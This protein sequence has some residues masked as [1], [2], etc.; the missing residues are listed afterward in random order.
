MDEEKKRVDVDKTES[1]RILYMEDDPGLARLVQRRLQKR[2]YVVDI[3]PDGEQGL[4]MYRAA[5]Y[6]LLLIDQVMPV[7][8]GLEVIRRLASPG[9]LP[10]TIMVTGGGSER[11]AVEAMQLG[12]SDYIVKDASGGFFELLPS[13]IERALRQQRLLEE[14][15]QARQRLLL[16]ATALE[17]AAEGIV[18]TDR[19]GAVLWANSAFEK[20][21]GYA[22][23]EV[24]GRNLR[25]LR[26][27]QHPP[28][29]YEQMWNTILSGQTWHGELIN[30]HKDGTLYNEEMTI[31]PVRGSE[32]RITH[33]VA[34][35]RDVTL[36]KRAEKA[37]RRRNRELVLLNRLAQELT[38]TLDLQQVAER[39]LEDVTDITDAQGASVWLWDEERG[40]WL[41]CRAAFRRGSGRT[42]VNSR[43]R[44]GQGVAGWVAQTGKGAVVR[45][46][47]VDDR[48]FPE[49]DRETGFRT[50]SLLAVPLW[51][52]GKVVGTLEVVNKVA[53][54]FVQDDLDLLETLAIPAA[55][56]IDNARLIQAQR[57]YTAELQARNEELDA[58]AHTV[59]H[60]LKG[61]LG[62]VVGFAEVLEQD[63][64][65]VGDDELQRYLSVIAQHGRKMKNIVDE[66]L[67]L[68]GV[69]KTNVQL[70]RLDMARIVAEALARLSDM[71]EKLGAEVVLPE[72]DWPE[73]WGYAPWVEEVW[74][75]YLSNAIKYGGRPPRVELGFDRLE[76]AGRGGSVRFWVHDNGPGLSS[77][78]RAQLFVPFARISQVRVEGHGLGLSI[79]R[80]I[81]EKLGGQVGV[82]SDGR[83]GHG[84]RFFFTL[85]R[86]GGAKQ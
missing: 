35:K 67:L 77:E 5:S 70:D 42:P 23:Q 65:G 79:V 6:D 15:E 66:L 71:I 82:E 53:G 29:F 44:I 3:A 19:E 43:L 33:F 4:A 59:A 45:D 72:T 34:I 13:V 50:R 68:A 32:A 47:A 73:A 16:Q 41:V 20:L 36:R 28:A 60:D 10:P 27:D 80:R 64:E 17:S 9:A 40:D 48:F 18:I 26:S 14:G 25:L 46:A 2:G 7:Y 1:I 63:W 61:V 69:R 84:S 54:D 52:R 56:A 85:S 30:R 51:V 12:A 49:V 38:V 31:T 83:P 24:S 8:E 58:F 78:E 74:V 75:N 37:L 86:D 39:L 21:T 76:G 57:R 81:V 55:I 22:L 62:P 11:V